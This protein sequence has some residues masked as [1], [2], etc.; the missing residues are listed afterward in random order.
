MYI[1]NISLVLLFAVYLSGC[2]TTMPIEPASPE[3]I[4]RYSTY[5]EMCLEKNR[6]CKYSWYKSEFTKRFNG[7]AFEWEQLGDHYKNA[8]SLC[9][10]KGGKINYNISTHKDGRYVD[11]T[12]LSPG[13]YR[14]DT[15]TWEEGHST[16]FND[17]IPSMIEYLGRA[18]KQERYRRAGNYECSYICE[19]EGKTVFRGAGRTYFVRK[20]TPDYYDIK[21]VTEEGPLV[22]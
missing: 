22:E 5:G 20:G 11:M 17:Q 19:D 14:F 13:N 3:D 2:S 12:K 6:N 10:S 4:A 15:Y 8:K 1:K 18:A 21:Y 16:A 7:Y 9:E